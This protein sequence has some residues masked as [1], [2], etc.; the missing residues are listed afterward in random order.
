MWLRKSRRIERNTERETVT[1][2]I[3]RTKLKLLNCLFFFSLKPGSVIN[4][5]TFAI[6]TPSIHEI[7][8]FDSESLSDMHSCAQFLR[9]SCCW[10]YFGVAYLPFDGRKTLGGDSNE[11]LRLFTERGRERECK[12]LCKSDWSLFNW[13]CL[14]WTTHIPY[15]HLLTPNV[16]QSSPCCVEHNATTTSIE[17]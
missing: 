14:W 4:N 8:E 15:A 16:Y 1:I 5:Q 3:I 17:I 7:T 2:I 10:I 9:L 11:F 13:Y 12:K 6:Q